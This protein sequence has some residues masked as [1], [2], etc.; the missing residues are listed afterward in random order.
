M[1]YTIYKITNKLNS[2]IYIGKHQ[3]KNL[4]DGYM[5]SGKLIR[6]AVEKHGIEN[7]QKEILHVFE[8]EAEMNKA[9][10]RLVILS[11]DSYNLC[12]GG[13]G[14]WGYVNTEIW[15]K[16]KRLEHNRRVTGFRNLDRS[17]YDWKLYSKK[18]NARRAEMI[19]T[20]V[21]NPKTFQDKKHTDETIIK[22]KSSRKG[23]QT[24]EKN[25]Q[26]GTCWITDGVKNKKIKKEEISFWLEQGYR[27]GRVIRKG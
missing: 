5:G 19:K 20:G 17:K 10:A 14:G 1:Y 26:Y 23:K 3:T 2:K 6:R 27:R 21:L 16:D 8:T 24:A 13:Q 22:M 18:G 15:T 9:E 25:S 4:D 12:S 7:F 11:E